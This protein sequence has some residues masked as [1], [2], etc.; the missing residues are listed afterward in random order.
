MQQPPHLTVIAHGKLSY[1]HSK[2]SRV[3]TEAQPPNW[4]SAPTNLTAPSFAPRTPADQ[5]RR[6]SLV[7]SPQDRKVPL[8]KFRHTSIVTHIAMG[9]DSTFAL[10]ASPTRTPPPICTST[11]VSKTALVS[12]S[13]APRAGFR[14]TRWE[15]SRNPPM[16][17]VG[18]VLAAFAAG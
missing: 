9:H 10:K 11:P 16:R 1:L 14:N 17:V 13:W 15:I 4:I 7:Q 3:R 6:I 18:R 2:I 12:R 8:E 5:L